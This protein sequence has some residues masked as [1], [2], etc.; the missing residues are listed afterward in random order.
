MNTPNDDVLAEIAEASG[1]S[2]RTNVLVG[3]HLMDAFIDSGDLPEG[4]R[5][6]IAAMVG[7]SAIAVGAFAQALLARGAISTES[8]WV[9]GEPHRLAELLE[10]L[11]S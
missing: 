7:A 10:M 1:V 11:P 9:V 2:A 5:E 6:V 3:F 8:A 4:D